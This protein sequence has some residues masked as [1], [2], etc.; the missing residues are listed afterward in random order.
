[1]E[2]VLIS[3]LSEIS[4]YTENTLKTLVVDGILPQSC[5]RR[6][7]KGIYPISAITRIE[8]YKEL[9]CTGL[10]KSEVVALMLK[11]LQCE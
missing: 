10:K 4:G 3:E 1:M 5:G 8:R 6:N 2:Y 11:E 9:I 7:K